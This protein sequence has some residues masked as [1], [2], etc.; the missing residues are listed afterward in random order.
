MPKLDGY[1][2]FKKIGR[3]YYLTDYLG[4]LLTSMWEVGLAMLVKVNG[5]ATLLKYGDKDAVLCWFHENEEKL[6]VEANEVLVVFN[7]SNWEVEELNKL[8]SNHS[9]ATVFYNQLKESCHE[10]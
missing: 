1:N 4:I 9:Y 8:L 5:E 7:S 3:Q 10:N 6:E 2:H